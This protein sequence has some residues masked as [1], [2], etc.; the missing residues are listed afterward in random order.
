MA[1]CDVCGNDYDLAFEIR[2][3]DGASYT[4]DSFECAIHRLAPICAHC[5]CRVMG[6]G[7]QTER[8]MY[9]CAHCARSSSDARAAE[10]QDS[11][12]G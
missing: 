1:L 6:H 10:L 12:A 7:V 11:T 3:V 4:F 8:Q 2:T 9:C 5:Q